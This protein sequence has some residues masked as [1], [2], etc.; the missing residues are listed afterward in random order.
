M[1]TRNKYKYKNKTRRGGAGTGP[2]TVCEPVKSTGVTVDLNTLIEIIETPTTKKKQYFEKSSV[3]DTNGGYFLWMQTTK[4][5]K[6]GVNHFHYKKNEFIGFPSGNKHKIENKTSDSSALT[7]IDDWQ[8]SCQLNQDCTAEMARI[9][10]QYTKSQGYINLTEFEDH[11]KILLRECNQEAAA[12]LFKNQPTFITTITKYFWNP[13]VTISVLDEYMLKLTSDENESI[14][15][16]LTL[17]L[18]FYHIMDTEFNEPLLP[19]ENNIRQSIKTYIT[20]KMSKLAA[21]EKQ[22]FF[23][24]N[25]INRCKIFEALINIAQL[26]FYEDIRIY[27][28][29][30][31]ALEK[32]S[33]KEAMNFLKNPQINTSNLNAGA[34]Y[35]KAL[36]PNIKSF[37]GIGTIASTRKTNVI[38]S[39]FSSDRRRSRSRH[40]LFRA[41]KVKRQAAA[42][43]SAAAKS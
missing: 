11:I 33:L 5:D 12:N 6:N 19:K 38:H 37:F 16:V 2:G 25:N 20:K 41:A 43:E 40:D 21:Q 18:Y 39:I 14:K 8:S 24:S 3:S 30:K 4:K 13:R 27:S 26:N 32:K 36:S 34:A 1:K 42:S 22:V 10:E 28:K 15:K 29:D 35:E 7:K 9:K 17:L 23:M 31:S